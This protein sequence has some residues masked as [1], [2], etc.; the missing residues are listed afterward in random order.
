MVK[1]AHH[2]ADSKRGEDLTCGV[3]IIDSVRVRA[4]LVARNFE[5]GDH[6]LVTFYHLVVWT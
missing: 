4:W 6:L 1:Q 3:D 5:S 2:M